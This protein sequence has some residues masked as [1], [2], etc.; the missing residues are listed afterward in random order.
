[1]GLNRRSFLLGSG[2]TAAGLV[3]SWLGEADR[4][5]AA[6]LKVITAIQA[7][8]TPR[9]C[10]PQDPLAALLEGNER[11]A[12]AWQS[13]NTATTMAARAEAMSSLWTKGCYL[14]G[15]TLTTG[16]A[17]WASILSC[18]DSRVS[19]EW[20][21]DAAPADLFVIRSAG[22]TAFDNAIAS[23]EFGVATLHTPLIMV[24]GHSDCGAVKAARDSA[25]LTPLLEQLVKPIRASL[26]PENTLATAIKRNA[27]FAAKQLTQRSRVL[28]DAEV[29]GRLT[30]VV[31]YFDIRSGKVSL[32]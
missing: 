2:L 16:Q 20:I 12:A 15:D 9:S 4:A 11:F 8:E 17:P 28:A 22:N 30:I 3:G 19:P 23:L 13:N 24:M 29:D 1:M 18:A 27:G 10:Q 7:D 32:V 6:P 5:E 25:P 26:S 31:S 21:F 14:P